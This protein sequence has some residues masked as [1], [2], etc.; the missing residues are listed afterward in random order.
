MN[1]MDIDGDGKV[2]YEEFVHW[3]MK[4]D[5]KW[6]DDKAMLD[7]KGIRKIKS[8]AFVFD[9][10][11]VAGRHTE[12]EAELQ[13]GKDDKLGLRVEHGDEKSSSVGSFILSKL[14]DDILN[15]WDTERDGRIDFDEFMDMMASEDL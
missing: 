15:K 13:L 12:F 14:I 2:S 10:R 9:H 8:A 7:L 5:Q 1:E 11:E 3:I 4:N 6:E